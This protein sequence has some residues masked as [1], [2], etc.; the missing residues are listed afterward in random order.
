MTIHFRYARREDV[1]SIVALLADDDIA[2]SRENARGGSDD[3]YLKAFDDM[4][5]QGDNHYLLAVN[6]QGDILGCIQLTLISGLSRSGMKRAQIE[7]VRIAKS[8]RGLGIGS[9]LM[10][11]AH[12]IARK[13]GCGLVQLTT[14]RARDDALRFYKDLGYKNSH[15]G[16]K[17][18]L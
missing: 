5:A 15:H 13:N 3:A 9:K 1:H 18:P 17:L 10:H 16:L 14:D 6:D 4:V 8:T 12:Q 7:G 2:S 11:E